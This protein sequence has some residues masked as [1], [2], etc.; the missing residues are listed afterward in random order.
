MD[1]K[2]TVLVPVFNEEETIALILKKILNETKPWDKEIIVIND[3]STDRTR[4][5][6]QGFLNSVILIDLAKN[7]GK[8]AALKYGLDRATGDVIII[9][10]ADLEYDPKDYQKLFAPILEGR[11]KVV[12]GSRNLAERRYVYKRYLWGGM[13]LT[14]I[15]NLLFKTR[16]T[17]INTGYKV[18]DA[19]TL[20]EMD[21]QSKGFEVCEEL[22]IKAL[23]RKLNIVEVPISYTPRSFRQ[24]K[25][26]RWLDGLKALWAIFY[27]TVFS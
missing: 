16:L 1:K 12:F 3:G 4:Q 23:K 14:K 13:V 27:F 8:G 2:I 11:T 21:V 10:D 26:I 6:L 15:I 22:T 25:K 17:D 9:Q 18:F 24:G 5:E 20:K 19:K 7:Q